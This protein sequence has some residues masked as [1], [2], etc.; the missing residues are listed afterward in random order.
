MSTFNAPAADLELASLLGEL[1]RP[2]VHECNNFLNNLLMQLA[3]LED[4]APESMRADFGTLRQNGK[5]LAALVAEWQNFRKPNAPGPVE[6]DL[7]AL[8]EEVRREVAGDLEISEDSIAF[9]G[10][11]SQPVR[12][13][14]GPLKRLCYFLITDAVLATQNQEPAGI[15]QVQ[16]EGA[17]LRIDDNRAALEVPFEEWFSLSVQPRPRRLQLAACSSLAYRCKTQLGA[18]RSPFGGV[19]VVVLFGR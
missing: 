19:R 3:L 7:A 2:V 18:E 16:F 10:P 14:P 8:C 17:T 15:V 13:T 1:V 6:I 9:L 12:S 4:A 11:R 5:H